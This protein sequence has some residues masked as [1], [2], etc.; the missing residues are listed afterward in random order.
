[1]AMPSACYSNEVSPG[2]ESRRQDRQYLLGSA[3]QNLQLRERQGHARVLAEVQ[4]SNRQA[5]AGQVGLGARHDELAVFLVVF[6]GDGRRGREASPCSDCKTE[7]SRDTFSRHGRPPLVIG[8]IP[9]RGNA[10]RNVSCELERG[11]RG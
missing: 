2:R 6:V 8:S 10:L 5:L 11:V 9:R 7:K 3:D 1:M 4:T